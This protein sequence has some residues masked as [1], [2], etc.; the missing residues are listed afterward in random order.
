MKEKPKALYLDNSE[1]FAV[2]AACHNP[3]GPH[4]GYILDLL[5]PAIEKLDANWLARKAA[6]QVK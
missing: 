2:M 5:K 1:L 3:N 4:A 6:G